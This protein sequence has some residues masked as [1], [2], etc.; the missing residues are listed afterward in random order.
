MA[1]GNKHEK[2][3]EVELHEQIDRLTNRQTNYNTSLL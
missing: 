2:F 3:G 1:K